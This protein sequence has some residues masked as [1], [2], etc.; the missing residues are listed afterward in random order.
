MTLI[1]LRIALERRGKSEFNMWSI[2]SRVFAEK[3]L[4]LEAFYYKFSHHDRE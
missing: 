2:E 3:T 1:A 4:A